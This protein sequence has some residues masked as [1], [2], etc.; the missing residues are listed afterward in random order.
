M[1]ERILFI[2]MMS[3][4][5]SATV[6]A[7]NSIWLGDWVG[8][9]TTSNEKTLMILHIE[10]EANHLKASM[11]LPDLGVSSWPVIKLE[12]YNNTLRIELPSDSGIQVLTLVLNNAELR[13]TWQESRDPELAKVNLQRSTQGSVISEERLLVRGPAGKIGV[14]IIR[15]QTNRP[16]PA[17][18]FVHGSG[19]QPRDANRYDAQRFANMGI[20]AVIFDKRGVGETQG[21]FEEADFED[22]AADAIAVAKYMQAQTFISKVGF[23][24]H[25]QGGWISTLAASLWDKSAFVITISGPAVSPS[26]ET[27]WDV[28]QKLRKY[29]AGAKAEDIARELIVLWHQGIRSGDWPNFEKAYAKAKKQPWFKSSG[30]ELFRQQPEQTINYYRSFMDYEPLPAIRKMTAPYLSILAL[31]DESID[32]QESID[33]LHTLVKKDVTVKVYEGFDHSLRSLGQDGRIMRWPERPEDFYDKQS[34][35]I[36]LAVTQ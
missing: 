11:T 3:L 19:P 14:S 8:V 23:T 9:S 10:E 20:A 17:I 5:Y 24:G 31:E 25:S 28:V 16:V 34:R 18:V 2:V 15:P 30:L 29:G 13:G 21:I 32:A 36:F 6:L 22:L 33:I 27:Q 4:S 35:F 7:N 26:R 1:F 12:T